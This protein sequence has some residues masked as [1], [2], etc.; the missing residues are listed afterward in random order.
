MSAGTERS[1]LTLARLPP[2]LIEEILVHA[3]VHACAALRNLRALRLTLAAYVRAGNYSDSHEQAILKTLV[4][5]RWSAGVQAMID[6]DIRRPFCR[7]VELDWSG[8][9]LPVS[10]IRKLYLWRFV[11]IRRDIAGELL[12]VLTHNRIIAGMDCNDLL[13]WGVRQ[14]PRF[15]GQISSQYI[16]HGRNLDQL[17][18]LHQELGVYF[19]ERSLAKTLLPL[20]AQHGRLDL[21]QALDGINPEVLQEHSGFIKLAAEYGHLPVVQYAYGRLLPAMPLQVLEVAMRRGHEDVARWLYER[22]PQ[23]VD[24]RAVLGIAEKGHVELLQHLHSNRHILHVEPE[25][26][27]DRGWRDSASAIAASAQDIRVPLALRQ[28]KPAFSVTGAVVRDASRAFLPTLQHVIRN[29]SSTPDLRVFCAAASAGRTDIVDW[30][31]AECPQWTCAEAV[32]YAAGA[33]H[34]ELAQRLSD[35]FGVPLKDCLLQ[36]HNL[37]ALVNN[38]E[39]QKLEWA[40][41]HCRF[42]CDE[43]LLL[44][45]IRSRNLAVAQLLQ[46]HC[47]TI[48]FSK[49]TLVEACGTG[50]V[51]MVQW[52]YRRLPALAKPTEAIDTAAKRGLEQIVEWLHHNTGLSCTTHAM[53]IAA[54]IG[55]LDLVR[56]LHE[57]RTEGCTPYAMT[58]AV[59]EGHL[60]IAEY[61]RINRKEGCMLDTLEQVAWRSTLGSIQWVVKHYP[62]QLTAN[63]LNSAAG[64]SRANVIEYF[65]T[66]PNAPFSAAAMDNAAASGDLDLVRWFHRNRTEGCTV[67]A[68]KWAAQGGYLS[69]V[70]FLYEHSYP[71]CQWG[72]IKGSPEYIQ[73]W[74]C[75]T[76]P[77]DSTSQES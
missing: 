47:R 10:S 18:T 36:P 2:E 67:D 44:C 64:R 37:Q 63:A 3:G 29:E 22:R 58:T 35:H 41:K 42:F 21:V 31:L 52:V 5:C 7:V 6:A 20:A 65:H 69:V 74:W 49:E 28:F 66:L 23:A 76:Q 54:R 77:Q 40:E 14:V 8:I 13:R 53:N 33:G 57:H 48:E 51:L 1:V 38:A 4:D 45:G 55:R 59:C 32:E 24:W 60:D 46:R 71:L 25:Y 43:P 9:V 17:R 75:S 27:E 61:L 16:K 34:Q 73:K 56:F 70:K 11:A 68:M 19:N 12:A 39:L 30:M 72:D 50:N 26:S 15:A 62:E